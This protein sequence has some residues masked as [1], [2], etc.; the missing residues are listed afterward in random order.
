MSAR[1][2]GSFAALRRLRMTGESI[3]RRASLHLFGSVVGETIVETVIVAVTGRG[4]LPGVFP[5]SGSF[6]AENLISDDG[7]DFLRLLFHRALFFDS[8]PLLC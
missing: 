1:I 6:V 5:A 7:V 2:R 8:V 3:A 4:A